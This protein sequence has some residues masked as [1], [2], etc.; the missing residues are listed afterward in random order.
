MNSPW[1]STTG[2][3]PVAGRTEGLEDGRRDDCRDPPSGPSVFGEQPGA[4]L[5]HPGPWGWWVP[6]PGRAAGRVARPGRRGAFSEGVAVLRGSRQ[7]GAPDPSEF[8]PAKSR[9]GLAQDMSRL[10]GAR[11]RPNW[12]CVTP[13]QEPHEELYRVLSSGL[14]RLEEAPSEAVRRNCWH[15]AGRS[16]RN[17]GF[18]GRNSKDA[19]PVASRL[20]PARWV[21]RPAGRGV[22]GP[23]CEPPQGAR[24]S[25]SGPQQ[26]GRLFAGEA[27]PELRGLRAH[28]SL[29]DDFTPFTC[30]ED[31]GSTRSASWSPSPPSAGCEAER[32]T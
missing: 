24:G 22:R 31:G 19:S 13:R 11:W 30:W 9:L 25:T 1:R 14:D 8:A 27:P 5:L 7:P 3:A 15:W 4:P 16:C 28:L 6:W 17:L 2:P 23:C 26:L 10:A 18:G 21:V 20:T 29:L 32:L 12:C